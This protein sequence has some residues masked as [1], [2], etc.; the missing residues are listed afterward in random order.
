GDT[1]GDGSIG[2][3]ETA[4][5]VSVALVDNDATEVT[6]S[7][8]GAQSRL[9]TGGQATVRVVLGRPLVAPEEL[10]VPVSITGTQGV[11][12]TA[13]GELGGNFCSCNDPANLTMLFT[14]GDQPSA[15][16]MVAV[17][18]SGI[19]TVE[20]SVPESSESGTPKMTA[21][22]LDGGAVR[23]SGPR[24]A[25]FTD[26]DGTAGAGLFIVES[27]GST[28]V[29]EDGTQTDSYNVAL[30]KSPSS[31]VTVTG[32]AA[33][34]A[35]ITSGGAGGVFSASATLTFTRT[36]W[37]TFQTI[38]VKGVDDDIRNDP[39]GLRVVDITHAFTSTDTAYGNLADY[40]HMITVTDDDEMPSVAVTAPTGNVAENGGSK[41]V[42]VELSR[43]VLADE[44]VTVPLSVSGVVVGEDFTFDLD[45][46]Q[47]GVSLSTGAPHSAQNPAVVFAPGSKTAKLRFTA[48]ND[49]IR[50]SPYVVIGW[51]P[52][53]DT[54]ASQ[55]SFRIIDDETGAVEVP[56]DWPLKPSGLIAGDRFRLLFV[57]SESRDA[58]SADIAEYNR[59]LWG[60][61]ARGG[62]P[63]LMPYG[64]QVRVLGS[65]SSRDALDNTATRG[66]GVPIYWL[67]GVNVA[68]DYTDFYDGSWSGDPAA[69]YVDESGSAP[70][71][72]TVFTG[73]D[74]D[75]T[76][77]AYPLGGG[78]LL[79]SSLLFVGT[80]NL[81]LDRP[82]QSGI[83]P[84]NHA[85][86]FYGLSPVFVVRGKPVH[87]WKLDEASGSGVTDS[88]GRANGILGSSPCVVLPSVCRLQFGRVGRA[89]D[90]E[91]AGGLQTIQATPLPAAAGWSAALW[92]KRSADRRAS[93]LFAADGRE[94][95]DTSFKL[96]QNGSHPRVG[97][98]RHSQTDENHSS[99]YTA[100]LDQWVHLAFVGTSEDTKLYVNGVLEW[101]LGHAVDLPLNFIG[102]YHD[103]TGIAAAA[104]DEINVY[105][106]ALSAVEI[107]AIYDS[108]PPL[109]GEPGL[110]IVQTEG[111]TSVPEDGSV[112]DFYTVVL[113]RKPTANVTVKVTAGTGAQV[114]SSDSTQTFTASEDLLFTPA[115]WDT[116]RTVR[117]RGTNDDI[118]NPADV[119]SVAVSHAVS[120]SDGN[121]GPSLNKTITVT[122]TDDDTAGVTI[123]ETNG[124][125]SVPENGAVT[126]SWTVVLDSEP[127][128]AVTVTVTAADG[129]LVDGPASDESF[130]SSVVLRF[131]PAN[132]N[133][134]RTVRAKGTRDNVN[135]AAGERSVAVTHVVSSSDGNYG[136]SLNES[137]NVTVID[138]LASVV[139]PVGGLVVVEGDV[140]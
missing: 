79:G 26:A 132:W 52:D 11:I 123:D 48:V 30:G 136:T 137:I 1:D 21:T 121:Y 53:S 44:T 138:D 118:D 76:K 108:Y 139:L 3:G 99:S 20:L 73:S 42:T 64:S 122:V 56:G 103:G 65:T 18:T 109:A 46:S 37:N 34:G 14:G 89:L 90:M 100:P 106:H 96:E 5:G 77:I 67:S 105:A 16:F 40:T 43:V 113:E 61:V 8:P 58:T 28:T 60:V 83:R 50:S 6:L 126:D 69:D 140:S 114:S 15:E 13:P 119:R 49:Y 23:V 128:G 32:T 57:S 72:F 115:N 39:D 124:S 35:V 110:R 45:G 134:V 54:L 78:P 104:F 33:D 10:R 116:A 88:A 17:D 117:V 111:S 129:V 107:K 7:V 55:I 25:Y 84:G 101:T 68:D 75:G 36:N 4:T 135:T 31:G 98:T 51:R 41:V 94:S 63:Q 74:S 80:G 130:E 47:T 24:T 27:D 66:T 95:G 86:V 97:I 9:F 62:H 127:T 125:T 29:P 91:A 19:A 22:G 82:L 93:V 70:T 112:V 92:V 38:T 59:W 2:A 71:G 87:Q 120:S 102:R 133:S 81:N 131:T 85:A 12:S